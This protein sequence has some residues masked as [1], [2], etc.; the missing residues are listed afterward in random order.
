MPRPT[1]RTV[2]VLFASVSLA[3]V[4][5]HVPPVEAE[6]TTSRYAPPV[7]GPIV[8][9]FDLPAQRWQPGN[10]GIDYATTPGAPVRAAA[11]GT[12]VF[13]GPVAGARHVT[14]SH[15]DGL[16]TSY[17]FLAETS[18]VTGTEVRA[19]DQVGV[20]GATLHFGVRDA[21]GSYLDPEALLEGR[22]SQRPV[23]VPGTAEGADPLVERRH[24][25]QVVWEAGAGA[26][27]AFGEV[28]DRVPSVADVSWWLAETGVGYLRHRLDCTAPGAAAPPPPGRR[29]AV[30]VS[31]LG[32]GSDGNSAFELRT[33]ALGYAPGD[34]VRFAYTGGRAP[35]EAHP[36]VPGHPGLAGIEVRS[37]DGLDSQQ[38]LMVSADRLGDLVAEVAR[39]EPGVPIDVLAHSQGGVVARLALDRE[40]DA[41]RLPAQV[42]NLVTLG[43]P[44]G[45]ADLADAVVGLET[46]LVGDGVL[47]AAVEAGFMA[48]LDPRRP[49]IA[50]LGTGS[51]VL[52]SV[53]DEPLPDHV[54]FTTVGARFD[55]TV[56]ADRTT[57]AAADRSVV[58]DPG[59]SLD[60]HGALTTDPRAV[61]EISLALAGAPPMCE[62]LADHVADRVAPVVIGGTQRAGGE[63][64]AAWAGAGW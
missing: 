51:P 14:V 43:S 48:P 34:V 57:D 38:P 12:V 24:L 31:G 22:I 7:D 16:R 21:Q 63:A 28:L 9:S 8:E 37:F 23:L 2:A 47:H 64:L 25:L 58:V 10:R 3:L 32:T 40:A 29:I 35:D 45:G 13:A 33:D 42:E 39:R 62:S 19:G 15:P 46:T 50:Q 5:L 30:V 49:A 53:R 44:H 18:V 60:A 6:G 55:L 52:A 27:G 36:E 20:A 56:P 59:L 41:D 61:R 11:G 17:S 4:A 1:A 26:V 54:R